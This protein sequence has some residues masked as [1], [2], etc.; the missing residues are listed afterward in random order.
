M[1]A[2]FA[3]L[4]GFVV[5][6]FYDSTYDFK[7]NNKNIRNL[8]CSSDT[9]WF[10]KI[11][12]TASLGLSLLLSGIVS[13]YIFL[14]IAFFDFLAFSYSAPPIKLRNRPYWDWIF[15][16]LWKGLIIFI[17]YSF[18]YETVLPKDPFILGTIA[19]ILLVSLINQV[20]NQIRDFEVDKITSAN[21]SVQRLGFH[22][23]SSINRAL[24]MLFY[25]FSFAFSYFL[26]LYVTMILILINISLYFFVNSSK[27]GHII[28]FTN[29]WIVVLFLENFIAYFSYHQQFLFSFWIIAMGVI[30]IRHM[31]HVKLLT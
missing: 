21:N 15:V 11:V 22:N 8:F 10:G 30:A 31:K 24:L 18:F 16:F 19:I 5:N 9:K 20:H 7:E 12:L 2:F 28:E 13:P 27:Y 17:G 25:T 6:D 29:I 26:N 1:S 3:N 14:M 23:A 4:F